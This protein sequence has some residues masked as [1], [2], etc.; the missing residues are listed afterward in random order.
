MNISGSALKSV[1]LMVPHSGSAR[2]PPRR[3][4][5][6]R[7]TPQRYSP[8]LCRTRLQSKRTMAPE[9]N[10]RAESAA[11][12]HDPGRA[13]RDRRSTPLSRIFRPPG[14]VKGVSLATSVPG[15]RGPE[16][17]QPEQWGRLSNSVGTMAPESQNQCCLYR[18]CR[19]VPRQ[20]GGFC[21]RRLAIE[22]GSF[23]E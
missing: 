11:Q 3:S 14:R 19:Q 21:R 9:R 18:L 20:V 17:V 15:R 4:P 8:R 6:P 12:L 7:A 2:P 16:C 22:V 1:V 5:R 23:A 13:S 10:A